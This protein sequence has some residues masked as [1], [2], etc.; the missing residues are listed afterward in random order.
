MIYEEIERLK[1]QG[2]K[3]ESMFGV[4]G[5]NG[6]YRV[7]TEERVVRAYDVSR[8]GELKYWGIVRGMYENILSG[9]YK[10]RKR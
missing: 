2:Y 10:I 1:E 6:F 8:N 3:E 7:N 5:L 4:A 9:V